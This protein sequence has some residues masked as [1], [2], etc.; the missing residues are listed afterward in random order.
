MSNNGSRLNVLD[1]D[2]PAVP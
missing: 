1:N 2:E